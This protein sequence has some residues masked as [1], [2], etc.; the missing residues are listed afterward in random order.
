M[1]ILML[2]NTYKPH[3]GGVARS[4]EAFASEFRRRG[5]RVLIVAP[6]FDTTPADEVDVLR[7]PALQKFN[8]SDFAVRLPI[9]GYLEAALQDFRPD[10]VHSHHPFLLGDAAL[11]IASV[12]NVPVVFQHHTMYERYTHYV[13]GDSP[14]L[15]RFVIELSTEYA[16]LCDYVV[17]PSESVAAVLL[18][19]G[20][21]P[22]IAVVPT[23]VDV[24]CFSEG[25][26]RRLRRELGI[27]QES[28]VVGH[29]GRLAPEKNL[30]FLA[31]AVSRFL[32]QHKGSR[33][34]LVG[35]GPSQ[36]AVRSIFAKNKV[37]DR[38][39]W[40]GTRTGRDLVDCY[41][42]MD[43]FAF[44]SY[45][46]TQGMVLTEAMAAGCPVVALDAPGVREVVEDRL[47]GRLLGAQRV[48]EFAGALS[49]IAR[50]APEQRQTVSAAARRTAE[51]FSMPRSADRML[52]VYQT[53]IEAEQGVKTKGHTLDD[54]LWQ[55]AVRRFE[56]EWDLWSAMAT[57]AR[58]ALQD[59][60]LWRGSSWLGRLL[61]GW[62]RFRQVI[63]RSEWD[64]RLLGYSR[65]EGTAAEP[66]LVLIQ[67]DGLSRAQL[68]RALRRH[69][70]PFLR[71]LVRRDR[72]RLHSFYSGIPSSTP[73]VQGE[74]FYGV[75]TAVPA[76][77]F[78]DHE[79]GD[80]ALMFE[81]HAANK[82]QTRL[83]ASGRGLLEGGSAYS[84]I[85]SGGAA[86]SHFCPATLGWGSL[87]RMFNPLTLPILL[88]LHLGS[89][90]RIVALLG[91]ELVLAM[92]DCIRGLISGQA[93]FKELK[94]VPTRV[95]VSIL[96]REL[97][98][99]G[100]SMDA[101]RGLPVIHVNFLG[102]DEQAHRRGPDSAFAHWS[103]S[104]IDGAIRR[105]WN[106]A[107]RSS[108][109]DYQVW[110]YSDHGQEGTLSY[111]E[112]H[113]RSVTDAVLEILQGPSPGE[114]AES[115][116]RRGEQLQRF[117]WLGG[118]WWSRWFESSLPDQRQ[119]LPD[120]QR[121]R[122]TAMGPLGH[123]YPC[124]VLNA[125]ERDE[126]ARRLVDEAKIPL[127]LAADGPGEAIAWTAQG[128]FRLPDDAAE[129]FGPKHAFA[130][131]AAE[132][133]AAVCHHRDAGQLVIAGWASG[134]E[135]VTFAVE[136][137]SH[138][139]AGPHE[140]H[141]F[142]LLPRSASLRARA[143]PYLRPLDLRREVLHTLGRTPRRLEPRPP[144]HAEQDTIR[145]LTYN[146]H[147][148][149]G[150]D[151][152]VSPQRIARLIAEYDPDVVALQDVKCGPDGADGSGQAQAIAR[153]LQME[154]H[155]ATAIHVVADALGN[156]VLS[157]LP[158]R[159][160]RSDRL[161]S[162]TDKE[163]DPR[164]A[165][166]VA[167]EV[168]SQELHVLNV[169]LGLP[170]RDR[171]RQVD[172]ILGGAWLGDPR[173]GEPRIVC[174]DFNT[175]RRSRLHR[176]LRQSLRDVP[177]CFGDTR[178]RRRLLDRYPLSRIGNVYVGRH[179]ELVSIEVPTSKRA[180]VASDH[181]PVLV[182]VRL[183]RESPAP[184]LAAWA[185]A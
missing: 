81:P 137:G 75:K 50:L 101:A 143:K 102:Y 60:R 69:R 184:E 40:A 142:L 70:L 25:D 46:E 136:N 119:D 138:A 34:L 123:V 180:L 177:L 111:E 108:R 104:G 116:P 42:A 113:G 152:H 66:G 93:V 106:S 148:C 85:Y 9:P 95:G 80:V 36:D 179:V 89:V 64:I 154:T 65:S 5:H 117:R 161:P 169:H 157:R 118:G 97:V 144:A 14:V 10:V 87:A 126:A 39:H 170:A 37:S 15:Q 52:A 54:S 41:H 114:H 134:V 43:V 71:R 62:R 1:N 26:G 109:R 121:P 27:P 28:F 139:G 2:T 29:L 107:R 51:E 140:T 164:G 17:A 77:S 128:R 105:I 167:V 159:L 131:E 23:G 127:V 153:E 84:D 83:A 16:N 31:Q 63:S 56:A 120:G 20:V 172:A 133:L 171:Q 19:R 165:M 7:V 24:P 44:A 162:L 166:W 55:S 82:V 155:P 48:R 99:I 11:R 145:V 91:I 79:T 8:G 174:G 176:R 132:D 175:P 49:W 168:G 68:E 110:I 45:S 53:L 182:E 12:H 183:R 92:V 76:F 13:P 158:L 86:E 96:L 151:R 129:V 125:K 90:I 122:V 103:L 78:R 181:L 150:T 141:G 146:V 30:E 124:S 135:P 115:G 18:E 61:G 156:A 38:V 35:S 67:I 149:Q 59:R 21:E 58:T 72:Y 160:V 163:G 6:Q 3:V 4:V 88:L 57:A 73:A 98:T 185:E 112:R 47:N 178:R 32:R 74:L 147:R 173:F 33:F 130:R 94:F 22:P 100:A